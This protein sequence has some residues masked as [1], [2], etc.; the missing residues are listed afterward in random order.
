MVDCW[1]GYVI[2][3]AI[4]SK[5]LYFLVQRRILSLLRP[6]YPKALY[7]VLFL[8][9]INDIVTDIHSPIRLFAD[10]TT[11][12]IEVDDPQR[13]AHSINA[14]LAKI[15]SWANSWLV[16]FSPLKTESLL[17]SR[18]TNPPAHPTIY[19]NDTPI[20]EVSSHKH[21]GVVFSKTVYGMTILTLSKRKLGRELISC[22]H[23]NLPY[24]VN[25]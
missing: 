6:D 22:V 3:F 24:I 12:Y 5:G 7:L 17:F 11:L 21:L 1:H 23:S 2:T 19:S 16:T 25:H 18:K 20:Q 13:A 10:D 15:Q 8:V 14:D 9:Y 4:E